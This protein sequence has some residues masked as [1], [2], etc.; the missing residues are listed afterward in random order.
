MV[1]D[2]TSQ[3][4]KSLSE[5]LGT[6]LQVSA[7]QAPP[8]YSLR[9]VSERFRL[10]ADHQPVTR[11]ACVYEHLVAGRLDPVWEELRLTSRVM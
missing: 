10:W 3:T 7:R 6:F 11:L 5:L 9:E 8:T 1:T 4:D 2:Q